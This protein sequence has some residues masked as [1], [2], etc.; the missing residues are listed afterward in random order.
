MHHARIPTDLS[1]GCVY[2][3]HYTL[4]SIVYTIL[5]TVNTVRLYY[6][7]YDPVVALMALEL[8]II[9]V[10]LPKKWYSTVNHLI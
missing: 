8:I 3:I 1:S 6:K 10:K 7:T 5:Y 2:C 9:D 4:Y